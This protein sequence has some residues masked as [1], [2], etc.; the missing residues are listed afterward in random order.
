MAVMQKRNL[1]SYTI[2]EAISSSYGNFISTSYLKIQDEFQC[3]SN[4][5]FAESN[6]NYK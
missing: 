6:K 1:S 4:L 5:I 2:I 3:S